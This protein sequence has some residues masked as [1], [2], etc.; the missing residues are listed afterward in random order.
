[1][2]AQAINFI[3]VDFPYEIDVD[4]K[5]QLKSRYLQLIDTFSN[6]KNQHSFS[7][8]RPPGVSEFLNAQPEIQKFER[9]L[10]RGL[11]KVSVKGIGIQL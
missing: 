6:D 7:K 9:K 8:H 10:H 5:A 3:D 2:A 11:N 4:L 1:M